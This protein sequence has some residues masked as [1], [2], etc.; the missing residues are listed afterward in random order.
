MTTTISL[1]ISTCPNDTFCFH[2]LLEGLIDTPGLN[3]SIELHDVEKLNQRLCAGDFDVAKASFHA[4]LH[5][6]DRALVLR[7]GSALGFGVGP[8][9]LAAPGFSALEDGL[10]SSWPTLTPGKHTTAALLLALFYPELSP[11][12][13]VVF[14]EIMPALLRGEARWGVCIHEGRFSYESLGLELV[15]DLGSRWEREEKAPLPLGGILARK[16]LGRPILE[17]V[18]D[19]IRRSLL[20]AWEHPGDAMRSMKRH[21]QE[22][23]EEI[24]AAHVELYV[25]D[26][27]LDLGQEGRRALAS[28]DRRAREGH[29][30]PPDHPILEIL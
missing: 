13:P 29:L 8:V 10:A 30:L 16:R 9:L 26:W 6:A 7:S 28:L 15:E 2:A 20:Y 23:D 24:I 25:N 14:S 1:G 5:L 12:K 11:V 3:W 4:A 19:A 27:T 18:Q 21:A 22:M 17:E